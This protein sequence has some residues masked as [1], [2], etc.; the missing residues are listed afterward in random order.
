MASCT[1][2]CDFG[3]GGKLKA[4][5]VRAVMRHNLR[6]GN[7]SQEDEEQLRYLKENIDPARV[8]DNQVW[9][10]PQWQ[11][12]DGNLHPVPMPDWEKAIDAL[13]TKKQLTKDGAEKSRRSD[14]VLV[15]S[16]VLQVS[17]DFAFPQTKGWSQDRLDKSSFEDR[18]PMDRAKVKEWHQTCQQWL[19]SKYG[20]RLLSTQLH[21]DEKSPHIHAQIVPVTQDGRLCA[22]EFLS[23]REACRQFHDDLAQACAHLGLQRG[24]EGGRQTERDER[25]QQRQVNRELKEETARLEAAVAGGPAVAVKWPKPEPQPGLG[26]RLA[27]VVTGHGD[28]KDDYAERQAR[29]QE[30]HRES[31]QRY[32]DSH[33]KLVAHAEQRTQAAE[34]RAQAAEAATAQLR[35]QTKQLQE[36]QRQ[37]QR[38]LDRQHRAELRKTDLELVAQRLGAE[39]IE[40]TP[41][42]SSTTQWQ[43]GDR[44]IGITPGKSMYVDN[45]DGSFA[46]YGAI[47]LVIQAHGGEKACSFSQAAQW[48]ETNCGASRQETLSELHSSPRYDKALSRSVELAREPRLKSAVPERKDAL[49]PQAERFLAGRKISPETIQHLRESGVYTAEYVSQTGRSFTNLVVP[50]DLKGAFVRGCSEPNEALG[51]KA[52]KGTYG[53]KMCGAATLQGHMVKHDLDRPKEVWLVEGVTDGIAVID[54]FP[55]A[56]VRIVGGGL[57][58]DVGHVRDGDRIVLAFDSDEAGKQHTEFYKEKY[59][60]RVEWHRGSVETRT[61]PEG[62]KDWSEANKALK[63]T[64]ERQERE[65]REDRSGSQGQGRSYSPR[66]MGMER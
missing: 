1:V 64:Q 30:Q 19:Q 23:G 56:E 17:P 12:T 62:S 63:A 8:K 3:S 7:T 18:G 52:F 16:L 36:Q 26:K 24:Q 54:M 25:E 51:R 41:G 50:R 22:K 5:N 28:P 39:C 21:M 33:A 14:A 4:S 35:E 49:W 59:R 53:D 11:T 2:S 60:E 61:V 46:G 66:P 29:L 37:L 48:L 44:K 55:H 45:H 9:V 38:Q 47:D 27:S 58:P 13:E 32:A 15:R 34:R 65:E 43:L 31:V 40:G 6:S 10:N 42:R 20:D 57:R